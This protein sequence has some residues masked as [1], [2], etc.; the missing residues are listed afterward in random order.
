MSCLVILAALVFEMSCGK[1]RQTNTSESL[2]PITVVGVGNNNDNGTNDSSFS[3]VNIWQQSSLT[4][5]SSF[6]HW[7]TVV[8]KYW[9]WLTHLRVPKSLI[10]LEFFTFSR[11]GK[12]L[13]IFMNFLLNNVVD[14]FSSCLETG[15]T[16]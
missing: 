7:Q 13:N 6:N 14:F 15:L 12:S 5:V 2:T 3:D 16:H 1:D 11:F 4:M 8:G 10:V 9:L